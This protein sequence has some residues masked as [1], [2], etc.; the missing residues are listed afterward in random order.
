MTNQ[1]FI[2]TSLLVSVL[3]L[4]II[5]ATLTSCK[6]RACEDQEENSVPLE[7]L[8]KAD[9][10][11]VA[12]TSKDF[13]DK[14]ITADFARTRHTP[15]YY[16]MAYKF[17]IPEK[18]YVDA[19]IKF[20]VDSVGNVMKNRDIVGIPRCK[21]FPE[22]CDF[23]IDESTA[24]QIASDMELKEGIKEWD[25]AF[26]WDFKLQRYAWR[27]LSTIREYSVEDVYRAAGQEMII[28]PNTGEVL[29]LN[30]WIVN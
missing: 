7:V 10:F 18:P 15:P 21:N 17:F 9:S 12:S 8:T 2:K 5:A 6:C 22:E 4:F 26:M 11:I 25:A 28:D 1:F 23:N 13:F 16:E 3:T 30:D 19:V 14:Y 29:A 20:T 27:I 24:R